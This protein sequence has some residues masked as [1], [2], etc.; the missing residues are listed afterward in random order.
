ML[1]V[2]IGFGSVRIKAQVPPVIITNVAL[3]ASC[4]LTLGTSAIWLASA[5]GGSPPLQFKFWLHDKTSGAWTLLRDYSTSSS[6]FWQ[7]ASAGAFSVQVWVR[8][9]GSSAD[10]EAWQSS[11]VCSVVAV[12][13]T[14]VT[15]LTAT[16][17]PGAVATPVTWTATASGGVPPLQYKF[18]IRDE[19]TGV[20]SVLQEY[21]PQNQAPWTPSAAGA[22][23]AQVW[24][25]SA[26]SPG[27]AE[28]WRNSAYLVAAPGMTTRASVATGGTEAND[29]SELSSVSADG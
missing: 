19:T 23:T 12:P 8:S 27:S 2:T 5:F 26:L 22:Y 11:A 17:S 24:V 6:A 20:W 25:R 9:A 16:P 18:W 1:A 21:S 29:L 7:P 15:S 4:P 3:S 10:Y 28:A 14:V 13:P